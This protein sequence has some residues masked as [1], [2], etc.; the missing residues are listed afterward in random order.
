MTLLP[1]SL[2]QI[3][4]YGTA[5]VVLFVALFLTLA[6]YVGHSNYIKTR[7]KARFEQAVPV[8]VEQT[9]ARLAMHLA[10]MRG[11]R[12]LY[13]A[14]DIVTPAEL[15]RYFNVLKVHDSDSNRG[16]DG[17][18]VVWKVPVTDRGAH[19]ARLRKE[20]PTYNLSSKRTNDTL[21]PIVYFEA[22]GPTPDKALGWDVAQ[23]EVRRAVLERAEST[24]DVAASARTQLLYADGSRGPAGF[25][26]Y[27]PIF[28]RE[29]G[30]GGEIPP[31][32]GFVFGAFDAQKLFSSIFSSTTGMTT[33]EIFDGTELKKESLLFDQ[34]GEFHQERTESPLLANTTTTKIFGQPW[35]IHVHTDRKFETSFERRIPTLLLMLGTL[36]S[37]LLF[38]F[39]YAQIGARAAAEKFSEELRVSESALRSANGELAARVDDARRNRDALE[40]S[41][42]LQLATLEST[43]DG[44][45]VVDKKGRIVSYNRRFTEMWRVP[46]A[47]IAREGGCES[48]EVIN[49]VLD[50]LEDPAGFVRRIE[51]LAADPE[52]EC[53]DFLQFRD[54]RLFERH[55]RPQR[56][57]GEVIG[58][59]MSFRDVT[60]QRRAAEKIAA[61]KDRLAVTLKAISDAVVATDKEGHVLLMNPVAQTMCGVSEGSVRGMFIEKVFPLIDP[62]SRAKLSTPLA[63]ILDES[64]GE[65]AR[66]ALLINAMGKQVLVRQRAA[67]THDSSGDINGAV[68]VF[69]DVSQEQKAEQEL[70]RASKLES[71]GLLAGGIAHDFNNVL[72]GIVGNLSLLKEHPGLPAEVTER[73]SLLERSAYK[74]RQLTLQ[75]LTFAKGGSPIKQTAS[76]VEVI[77]ESAEFAL[78]GSNLKP[79]F[80]FAPD[81]AAV[82]IDT[83]QMSQVIQNLI[84]NAKHA[85]PDGGVLRVSGRNV[86]LIG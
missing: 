40:K 66:P 16:M 57:A 77:R 44:I 74:A 80:D 68:F 2:A 60:E 45:F 29:H 50:Q 36:G 18:G 71:I 59:V 34:N 25:V 73:L 11:V 33:L 23:N 41:L 47:L 85:M 69:R 76:I 19:I 38:G 10:M 42:S 56:A 79:E 52:S 67:P 7:E 22:L 58:R 39:V 53:C 62:D 9:Q 86:H 26:I 63:Q 3:K 17:I 27:L 8:A 14:S 21:Y 78:R 75:L 30:S 83:G 65:H 13:S 46:E 72:T 5:Y 12:A 35:S 48:R 54:G 81:I 51:E 28:G 82:E 55:S 15:S 70:L 64:L 49:H 31:V 6:G 37:F 4:G 24:R 84:I 61:E 20:Y 32:V 1:R 43:G